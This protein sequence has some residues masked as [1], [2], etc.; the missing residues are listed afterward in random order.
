MD[1]EIPKEQQLKEQR[2]RWL[3]GGL[4]AA[5]AIALLAIGSQFI[6]V[7]AV[8]ESD[9]TIRKAETGTLESSVS[10]TGKIVPLYEQAIVSP[11]STRIMEVYCTEGDTV[12]A[13]ESLLRLDLLSAESNVRRM[14]DE[15]SMKQN[16]IEQ[17]ALNNATYLTDLEMR[18]KSKEMAVSHLKAEVANERRL[19]SIGSGTG[20]RI[21]QAELA[22][23]TGLLE[24]EQL[25]TQL[26]NERKAHAASYRSKQ[27][28][29][30]ISKRN[31]E[32]MER[33]LEDARVKAPRNGI[34]TYLNK[35]LG[36]SIAA[37]EKLAVISDLSHFKVAGE[38]SESNAGK[39]AVGGEV[40]I[41]VGRH[42]VRG[43]ISNLTPQSKD[44][45]TEF[46]VIFDD[47]ADPHLRS[48]LRT[49]LNII[50]DTR[51]GIVR[52]PNGQYFQGPGDYI[53]FIK[54]DDSHLER[55][56][57]TLGDS[58]FDYVEVISGVSPGEEVVISDMATY[59]NSKEIKLK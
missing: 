53:L 1:K 33:T 36:A 41:R 14:G 22:Y 30:A 39:I 56:T 2:R 51:D 40:N 43:H 17:A 16:E 9:L 44:G 28:E 18:I 10:A 35:D 23:S 24:L 42:T 4:I 32:E 59:K 7:T 50:Y 31:L 12:K 27:L 29:G 57:V 49:E 48:G 20:D 58:N 5:G 54:R 11:V 21:R 47:D 25:R 55:R 52:I 3:K 46:S 6:F 26:R 19:D 8:K 37:G 45:M 13:G 34:V 15:V 38:I